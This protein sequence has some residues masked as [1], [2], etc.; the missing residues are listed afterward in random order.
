MSNEQEN[1]DGYHIPG[2]HNQTEIHVKKYCVLVIDDVLIN[3]KL[4]S[5][6]LTRYGYDIEVAK[7]VDDALELIQ[8]KHPDIILTDIH[9]GEEKMNALEFVQ[10]LKG[11]TATQNI[12]VI[13]ITSQQDEYDKQKALDAGCDRYYP[14][15]MNLMDL[16]SEVRKVLEIYNDNFHGLHNNDQYM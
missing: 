15:P 6:L 12:P 9:L 16:A 14:L 7:N 5:S 4:F 1:V 2:M 8:R 3:R 13:A 10:H 11:N